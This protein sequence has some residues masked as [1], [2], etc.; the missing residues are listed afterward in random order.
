VKKFLLSVITVLLLS[1]VTAWAGPFED[2]AAAD[3]RGNYVDAVR[4]YRMAAAQGDAKAQN[5]LGAMYY[6]G[7]GVT[8]DNGEAAKWYRKAADQGNADARKELGINYSAGTAPDADNSTTATPQLTPT[9]GSAE[10]SGITTVTHFS[11]GTGFF[12]TPNGYLLTDFHVIKGASR[13]KVNTDKGSLPAR[14]IAQDTTDD[15]ALLKV[16]GDFSCLPLGDSSTVSLGETVFTIG[17]PEP[18]LEGLSP[19]LTKGEVSSLNGMQDD[20]RMLQISVSVQPGNSGGALV[21]ESG[22]VVGIIEASLSTITTAQSTGDLLQNVNYATKIS[23]AKALLGTVSD[24]KSWLLPNISPT[25]SYTEEVTNVRKASVLIVAS[26]DVILSHK[27]ED[28]RGQAYLLSDF[29]YQRLLPEKSTLDK[30][31]SAL[32][33]MNRQLIKLNQEIETERRYMEEDNPQDVAD[34]NKGL[35]SYASCQATFQ[36]ILA[37][38]NPRL[39]NFNQ[40]L[41]RVGSRAQ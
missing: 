14:L 41:Q 18:E 6:N 27:L 32:L 22:N 13:I 16:E 19:K 37:L 36:K 31:H 8:Q 33:H 9:P 1:A 4:F 24:S 2:G 12:L 21:D 29:D 7:R 5:S 23:Y 25:K 11:T 40:E 26:V 3:S 39:Y 35:N 10:A 17:F 38:Y 20:S 15:I 30:M 34:Y 28:G